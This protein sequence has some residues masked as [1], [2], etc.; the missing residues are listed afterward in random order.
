MLINLSVCLSTPIISANLD[1]D[2]DPDYARLVKGRI[3]KTLLGEVNTAHHVDAGLTAHSSLTSFFSSSDLRIHRGG[4]P[5]R[6]LFH[7]GQALAGENSSPQAGGNG[8]SVI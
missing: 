2:D 3:E 8:T 7:S 5:A 6:R 1:I 4:F